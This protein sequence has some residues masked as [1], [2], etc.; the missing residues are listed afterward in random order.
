[1]PSLPDAFILTK[2]KLN[3][4]IRTDPTTFEDTSGLVKD[5]IL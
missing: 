5:K 2:K 1:M 4:R 3:I